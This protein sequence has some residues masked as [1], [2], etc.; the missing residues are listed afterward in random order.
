MVGSTLKKVNTSPNCHCRG[1]ESSSRFPSILLSQASPG[2]IRAISY[3]VIHTGIGDTAVIHS[4]INQSKIELA[5]QP[6][7]WHQHQST[8]QDVDTLNSQ[9]PWLSTSL[10]KNNAC[11]LPAFNKLSLGRVS[12][13]KRRKGFKI[14]FYTVFLSREPGVFHQNQRQTTRKLLRWYWRWIFCDNLIQK[15]RLE[16][17]C[18]SSSAFELWRVPG[19]LLCHAYEPNPSR[20]TSKVIAW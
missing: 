13:H 1:V 15:M 17:G 19:E 5:S 10:T 4:W 9:W 8:V 7:R 3:Q 18:I 20:S 11:W 14:P 12:V 2:T 16:L 6:W